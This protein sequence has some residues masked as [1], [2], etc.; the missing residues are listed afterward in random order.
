MPTTQIR[1]RNEDKEKLRI[2]AKICGLSMPAALSEVIEAFRRKLFI[3]NANR[4][5]EALLKDGKLSY[6]ELDEQEMWDA[7]LDDEVDEL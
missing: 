6:E 5:Y 1:I 4:Q 7:P 3:L 2:I